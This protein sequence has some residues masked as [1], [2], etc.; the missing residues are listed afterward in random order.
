LKGRPRLVVGTPG[1]IHE[2]YKSRKLKLHTVRMIIVD[3]VDQVFGL[4]STTEVEAI[5]F[6]THPQRQIGFFSAT[7]PELMT[8]LTQRWMKERVEVAVRPDQR[9]VAT[10]DNLYLVC[11]MRDKVETARKLIRLLEPSSAL[12]FLN[13]TDQI[14]NWQSK[15]SYA[16]FKV[17]ALY[18]DADKQQRAGTLARFRDGRCQL[19]LAT[20]IAARGL[21]IIGL[22][23]V[24]NLDPPPDADYYVHRAGRTGRMGRTG[25]VVSIVA[26]Q[27]TFIMTKFE[28]Q[29]GIRIH[30]KEMNRGALEDA[31]AG[32]AV[33]RPKY[34]ARGRSAS[35][36][37]T[38]AGRPS[39]DRPAQGG[40]KSAATQPGARMRGADA[41]QAASVG[42]PQRER[43]DVRLGSAAASSPASAG[44]PRRD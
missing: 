9:V 5:L 34:G 43:A 7:Y 44:K 12:L 42:M 19:L 3:E 28:K 20:D 18:G 25:T 40:G 30:R 13:D 36:G 39:Q 31:A 26:P 37:L 38:G 32:A 27:E 29:L 24:V 33:N 8:R 6:N 17:E 4:S 21:D 11:E 16:G 1:R 15:L 41:A 23:L 2:L 10:V 35:E 22:P 14:A